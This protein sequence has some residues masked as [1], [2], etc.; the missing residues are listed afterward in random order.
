MAISLR[1]S[2]EVGLK[3]IFTHKIRAAVTIIGII[4]GVMSIMVVLAIINGMNIMTLRWMEERGGLNKIEVHTDWNYDYRKGGKTWFDLQEIRF[5][6]SQLPEVKAFNPVVVMGNSELKKKNQTF[7]T[8][9]FG[10]LPDMMLVDE[11]QPTDGRFFNEYDVTNNHNV[12]VL[13]STA[14]KELFGNRRGLGEYITILDQAFMV[15]GIMEEKY[16]KGQGGWG[17][18]NALEYMNRRSFIPLTTMLHKLA[19]QQKISEFEIKVASPEEASATKTKLENIIL[20]LRQGKRIF[21]VRSAKEQLEMMK[22]NS[23]I[24]TIIFVLIAI[25]SLLVGG[26][27]IMNIM[28]ASGQERTREIGVRL[29]VGARKK[30][31]FLQ[32]LVQTVLITSLGGVIGI[33]L[34]YS[35]LE[36]VSKYLQIT[37]LASVRMIWTA[38]IVSVGV[39]ITFGTAPAVRASNLDPVQ[40]LRYE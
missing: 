33:I 28:L 15:I 22:T 19:T 24:F 11:W 27:V 26:I 34:G 10:V 14:K 13:G 7:V 18:E 21:A 32:F 4:L 16:W 23:R 6:Q 20:N 9:V 31:I 2:L 29:A 8:A 37:L 35:I 1:E 17:R 5:I 38:L 25:V 40:A 39:G 3:D 36:Q 12:I 30:D